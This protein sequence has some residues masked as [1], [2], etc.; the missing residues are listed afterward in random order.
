MIDSEKLR[1]AVEVAAQEAIEQHVVTMRDTVVEAVLSQ[2]QGE[3]E[4]LVPPPVE[5]QPKTEFLNAA[6]ASVQDGASQTEILT[7]LLNGAEKFSQRCG[8]LV[9]RGDV[10]TGWQARSFTSD[11]FRLL[12]L[13]ATSGLAERAIRTKVAASGSVLNLSSTFVS[14]FGAPADG[15]G[16]VLP[17]VVRD[18]VAALLYA[19]GGAE[20][21]DGLDSAALEVLIKATGMWLEI[22]AHRRNESSTP[23]AV[24]APTPASAPER[25]AP[26]AAPVAVAAAFESAPVAPVTQ[27]SPS[28]PVQAPAA[29]SVP[30]PAVAPAMDEAHT[31]ARRFAKLLVEEIK[32]YNQMKVAEGLQRRDLYDRLREDIEKSRAAYKKRFGETVTDVDYFSTELVR[33][34][35][36]DDR[37]AFGEH[38][39]D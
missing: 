35:A 3:L 8:L 30:A 29:M 31:R 11:N 33:I 14:Q 16:I 13:D 4:R 24:G 9:V 27:V 26:P 7:S 17:L 10:A 23:A 20:G 2:I 38:F 32:L 25:P 39:P 34:L 36:N 12:R 5:Q 28:V 22:L 21:A 18:R 6:L 37:G 1:K 15:N 19:D